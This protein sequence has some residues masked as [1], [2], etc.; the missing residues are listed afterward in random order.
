MPQIS[1]ER[2][3]LAP[4][5]WLLTFASLILLGFVLAYWTWVWIA[6]RAEPRQEVAADPGGRTASANALFGSAQRDG[7]AAA[8]TGLAITLRGVMAAPAGKTHGQS[9][10]VLQL[11]GKQSLAV[12]EGE[13]ISPGIRLAEVHQDHVI[14]ER[15][16][17]REKLSWPEKSAATASSTS[18]AV[19]S[20]PNALNTSLPK[21]D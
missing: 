4:L 9:Y 17:V 14:L 1:L 20:M 19:P 16:G 13:D 10:A 11:D 5:V 2:P 12:H 3:R 21:K 6:P 7:Q 18:P 15:N 8:T